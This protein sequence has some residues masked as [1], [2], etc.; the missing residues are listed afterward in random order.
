M[1]M[2]LKLDRLK[3]SRINSVLICIA[4][5]LRCKKINLIE[6]FDGTPVVDIKSAPTRIDR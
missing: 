2:A 3:R 1:Q 4:S 5:R 6:P